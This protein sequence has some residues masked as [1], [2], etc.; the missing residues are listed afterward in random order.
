METFILISLT[1]LII[2]SFYQGWT[3][4]FLEGETLE[5]PQGLWEYENDLYERMY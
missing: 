5:E 1:L 3:N 2:N 4:E